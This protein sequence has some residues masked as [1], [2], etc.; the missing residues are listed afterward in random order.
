MGLNV[1]IFQVAPSLKVMRMT[2][3]WWTWNTPVTTAKDSLLAAEST[4]MYARTSTCALGVTVPKNI[5]TGEALEVQSGDTITHLLQISKLKKK[6]FHLQSSTHPSHHRVPD[7][8]NK[9]QWPSPPDPTL[10]PQLLLAPVCCFGSVHI[11]TEQWE[12]D[13]GRGV[14][15]QHTE[16][17]LRPAD[18]L[19]STHHWLFAQ[20]AE[21]QR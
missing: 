6:K 18:T 2:M 15:Q 10:H 7:G 4:A 21:Q 13:W 9:N 17:G 1:C 5:L 8:H 20:R 14:G 16:P 12:G 11:R 19:L 3:K